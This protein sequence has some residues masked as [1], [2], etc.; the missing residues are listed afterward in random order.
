MPGHGSLRDHLEQIGLQGLKQTNELNEKK[1][2]V[3]LIHTF[4]LP[5]INVLLFH[6]YINY[7][8]EE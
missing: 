5:V 3:Y 4:R 2:G 6:R 1:L 7:L 8:H